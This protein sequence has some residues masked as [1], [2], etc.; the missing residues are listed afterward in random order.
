M[1]FESTISGKISGFK[2][3]SSIISFSEERKSLWDKLSYWTAAL[4]SAT[5]EF[6]EIPNLKERVSAGPFGLDE[7]IATYHI[8]D[9]LNPE[10][11]LEKLK[12]NL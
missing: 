9:G 8:D 6:H 7:E 3:K 11:M 12:Q 2:S 1:V 4:R 5:G 10:Q